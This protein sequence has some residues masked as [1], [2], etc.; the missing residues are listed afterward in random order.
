MHV[1]YRSQVGLHTKTTVFIQKKKP[2]A[3]TQTHTQGFRHII[4]ASALR[5]EN[6]LGWNCFTNK[7]FACIVILVRL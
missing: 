1:F 7:H 6:D 3:N 2:H 5:S 4:S